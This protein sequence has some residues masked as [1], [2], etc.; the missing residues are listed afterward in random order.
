MKKILSKSFSKFILVLSFLYLFPL[1]AF[2]ATVTCPPSGISKF[3]CTIQQILNSIVPVLMTLGVVYF[4][5]GIV[6]YVIADGEEA[7]KTGR[8]RMVY[9]L[10]GFAVIVGMWGLVNIITT[11]F[12]IGGVNAPTLDTVAASSS[13]A[14]PASRAQFSDY[15]KFVTCT[16]NS[17]II[18]LIFALAV[19]MFTW[20]AVKFFIINSDEEAKRAQGKQFM[21]WGIIALTVM[22]SVW[23]VV[24]MLGATFNVGTDVLPKVKT[25]S[26]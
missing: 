12:S 1:F 4:V 25:Q 5:W 3:I 10:I 6:Q 14:I 24:A 7:K 18:P 20:G 16:I 9:G 13:C 23:G 26:Q 17:S 21:I 2:A 11:T 15:L 8:D 22:I 19:V